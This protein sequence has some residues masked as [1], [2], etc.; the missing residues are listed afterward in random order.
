M[1]EMIGR[2]TQESETKMAR[3]ANI[4]RIKFPFDILQFLRIGPGA[5]EHHFRPGTVRTIK[6]SALI[7]EALTDCMPEVF[8]RRSNV[9]M[10]R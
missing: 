8:N 1:I 9:R 4:V 7:N 6:K 5:A 2:K 10:H 3:I